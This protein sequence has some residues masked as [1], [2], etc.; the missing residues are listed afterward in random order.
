MQFDQLKRRDFI[1]LVGGTAAAWPLGARAQ[2]PIRKR[3]IGVLMNQ[4]ADDP[5][6]QAYV[7]AFLQG[8]Q[9]FGWTIGRNILIEYRY[10]GGSADRIRN[11][12]AELVS[13]APDVILGTGNFGVRPLRQATRT[14]PIVF[15]AVTDPVGGGYVASL[16]RP[17]SNATGFAN[18]EYGLSGKWPE[19]LKEI[20]PGVTRVGIIRDSSATGD[21]GQFAAIQSVSPSFGI[22]V[23]PIDVEEME[24]GV[25]NFARI[26]NAGL[27]VVSG[28]R[29]IGDRNRIISLPS[30]DCQRSTRIGFSLSAAG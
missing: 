4:D 16:A 17:D 20:A 1:T 5:V 23:S 24:R 11:Y 28:A 6:T 14:L 15:V 3:R 26:P 30:I 29:V 22:E 19:L 12:A 25:T 9:E 8:L 10:A 27:I 21:I 18:F 7:G 2:Q 13:L